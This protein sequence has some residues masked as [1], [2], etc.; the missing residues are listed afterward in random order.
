M[1]AFLLVFKTDKGYQ[2][3]EQLDIIKLEANLTKEI[4]RKE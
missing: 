3:R 1:K 2:V 4:K